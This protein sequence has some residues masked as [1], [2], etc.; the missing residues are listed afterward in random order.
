MTTSEEE[1]S[2]CVCARQ[3]QRWKEQLEEVKLYGIDVLKDLLKEKIR[4]AV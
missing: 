2:K 3:M 1:G 4:V